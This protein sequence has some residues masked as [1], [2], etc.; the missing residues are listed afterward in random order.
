MKRELK[1]DHLSKSALR[2]EEVYHSPFY[3]PKKSDSNDTVGW[4]ESTF[5]FIFS[6][7]FIYCLDGKYYNFTSIFLAQNLL[8]FF[9]GSKEFLHSLRVY[10]DLIYSNF[11]SYHW[12]DSFFMK[13]LFSSLKP[14]FC[15]QWKTFFY[16]FKPLFFGK[17]FALNS[18]STLDRSST[19]ILRHK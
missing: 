11:F 2:L 9:V 8:W 13:K 17:F 6:T 16:R 10:F 19:L 1:L 18:V 14:I 5:L 15:S 7:I 4:M 12:S 3:F